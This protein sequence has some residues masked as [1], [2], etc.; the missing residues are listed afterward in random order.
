MQTRTH[1]QGK[2][3]VEIKYFEV[4]FGHDELRQYIVE[5]AGILRGRIWRARF[6]ETVLP[7]LEQLPGIMDFEFEKPEDL[8]KLLPFVQKIVLEALDDVFE[9]LILY[10]PEMEAD[11]E[12]IEENATERQIVG[13]FMEVLRLAVPFEVDNLLGNLTGSKNLQTGSNSPY[14][15]GDTRQE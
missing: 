5:G 12:W 15:N 9:L 13:A 2:W 6:G 14:Q 10:S 8:L 3:Q 1:Q 11:R 7:L 4:V